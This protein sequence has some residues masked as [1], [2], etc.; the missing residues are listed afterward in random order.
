MRYERGVSGPAVICLLA[1]CVK[2]TTPGVDV[3]AVPT[4]VAPLAG[5]LLG[6]ESLATESP[7]EEEG[8]A[9]TPLIVA[10]S[11]VAIVGVIAAWG[12]GA[13]WDEGF[14]SFHLRD[15][16]FLEENTYA[17]GADKWG[18]M[19]G[20]YIGVL[21][22]TRLYELLGLDHETAA[23]VS[24]IAGTLVANGIEVADGFTS[25]GFEYG[26]VIFNTLGL[27][28]ALA[29]ELV[30]EVYNLVG[31][32]IGYIPSSDFLSNE[33]TF[34]RW[35]NDYSGMLFYLDF[36][37]KGLMEL[38]GKDPGFMRYLLAGPVWGTD[39]YSPVRQE[40]NDRRWLGLSVGLSVP[41]LLRAYYDND[42]GVE[43][44]AKFFEYYALPF[45]SVA[46][47]VD[48]NDGGWMINFGVANRV[49][50]PL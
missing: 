44:F 26:D 16:G 30:P 33:K 39:K 8:S 34:I 36:K 15:T 10:A 2:A 12:W 5:T 4:P 3:L 42:K 19:Y 21:M 35:I 40:E 32:R 20:S 14:S 22:V 45:F 25:F 41:E 9:Y 48:L 38:L 23:W 31:M 49:E 37:G 46:A 13:W 29:T 28:L 18:H 6:E 17:G 1:T 24:F 47:L 11:S 7:A 43:V 27:G 50:I